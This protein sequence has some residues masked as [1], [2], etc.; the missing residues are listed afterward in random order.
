MA[1]ERSDTEE[2]LSEAAVK[3]ALLISGADRR[4]YGKL[5]DEPYE[6]TDEVPK[7]DDDFLGLFED[8]E[9][10]APYPDISAELPGVEFEEEERRFQ[11]IL[12]KPEP[13]FWD[14]ATAALHN[15]GFDGNKTIQAG[16]AQALAA[17]HAVQQGAALVEANENELVYVITFDVPDKGLLQL[18]LEERTETTHPFPSLL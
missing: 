11:M 5:K 12:D 1:K 8:E 4:K 6:W 7:D 18:P 16:R 15:A 9:E 10:A 17:A 3:A 2:T 14:M 13:D